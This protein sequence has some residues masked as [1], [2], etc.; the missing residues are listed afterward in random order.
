MV[1]TL[2]KSAKDGAPVG[3]LRRLR[4]GLGCLVTVPLLAASPPPVVAIY[5]H[6]NILTGEQRATAIS[7]GTHEIVGVGDDATILRQK[8][9]GTRL[10]DLKGA[11]VMPGINDAHVHLAAAGQDGGS[12]QDQQTQLVLQLSALTNVSATQTAS[13]ETLSTG[14]G[15]PLVVGS[16]SYA[17]QTATGSDGM[18]HVLDHNGADI[19]ASLTSAGLGGTI[20]M[21]DKTIP[22]L[23]GQLD[24]LAANA[25][26]QP[27][28][29]LVRIVDLTGDLGFAALMQHAEHSLPRL[30]ARHRG[31]ARL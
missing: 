25:G 8:Q 10:Y 23:S 17:L 28:R 19:T 14:N 18:Q 21:R 20:Q 7:V 15:T 30:A 24:T 12:L 1:P 16:Q 13:G 29:R 5:Y 4:W 3:L 2:R 31:D 22:G 27:K 26:E 6:G 11:F 9:P